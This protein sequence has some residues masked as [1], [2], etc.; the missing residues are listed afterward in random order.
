MDV[1]HEGKGDIVIGDKKYYFDLRQRRWVWLMAAAIVAAATLGALYWKNR[2]DHKEALGLIKQEFSG[3]LIKLGVFHSQWLR[4]R[5]TNS[6]ITPS[7]S[8]LETDVQ[9]RERL[10]SGYMDGLMFLQR[11]WGLSGIVQETRR[12]HQRELFKR[13][14]GFVSQAYDALDEYA[15]AV[16]S[17]LD[18]FQESLATASSEETVKEKENQLFYLKRVEAQIAVVAAVL[19]YGRV[20]EPEEWVFLRSELRAFCL[21]LEAE[22]YPGI[23]EELIERQQALFQRK[24]SILGGDISP[25][26]C[27]VLPSASSGSKPPIASPID[28]AI[29]APD[30]LLAAAC[31]PFLA[32]DT[33][34]VY[35]YF[36]KALKGV[37]KGSALFAF[38]QHS[39]HKLKTPSS[40]PEGMNIMVARLDAGGR[41]AKAGLRVGDILYQVNEH[42]LTE[43][44]ELGQLL[45]QTASGDINLFYLYR[46]GQPIRIPIK[47]NAALGIAITPLG[48]FLL[49]TH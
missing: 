12:A 36:S 25:E 46:D 49:D 35:Y 1:R 15:Y 3:N 30:S 47:G 7:F 2:R 19:Q 34:A 8:P 43:T 32:N 27:D 28:T 11:N 13:H 38:I 26:P 9:R 48:C 14:A 5:P 44:S 16:N 20:L 23:R 29:T 42:K 6:P 24:K 41:A 31:F 4:A 39:I 45:G 22:R 40:Y 33:A 37:N 10:R 21:F 17:Y 18:Y